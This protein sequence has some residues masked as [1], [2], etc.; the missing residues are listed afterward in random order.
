MTPVEFLHEVVE[1]N[2][3]LMQ[4]EEASLRH[5]HNAVAAV[6]ALAARIYN[7]VV[8]NSPDIAMPSDDTAY[9]EYLAQA[10]ADFAL[11]R[12]VAKANKHAV[13]KRGKSRGRRSSEQALST[14]DWE[15]I[16]WC[17]LGVSKAVNVIVNDNEGRARILEAVALHATNILRI[18]M[19]KFGIVPR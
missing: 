2:L 9:R 8:E 12:D 3:Q 7:W 14:L 10:D 19:V 15:E 5:A 13:L 4:T 18:E 11:L 6:D 17:D 1:P 16:D